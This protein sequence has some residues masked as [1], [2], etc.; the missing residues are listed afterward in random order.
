M[1]P[2]QGSICVSSCHSLKELTMMRLS[3]D[4][5]TWRTARVNKAA[6]N[7]PSGEVGANRRERG[8]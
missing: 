6:N 1:I 2:T 4:A 5:S 3:A 8:K 7:D